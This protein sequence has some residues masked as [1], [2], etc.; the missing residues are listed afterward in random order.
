MSEP[1]IYPIPGKQYKHYKG[2]LYTVITLA[3]HFEKDEDLVVYKSDLFGS[4]YVIPLSMWF[5]LIILSKETEPFR[6]ATRFCLL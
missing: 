4:V 6:S 1:T 3:K 2:G 5:E